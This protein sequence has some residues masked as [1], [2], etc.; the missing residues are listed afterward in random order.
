[1]L[2]T[3]QDPIDID[4]GVTDDQARKMAANLNFKGKQRDEAARQIQRLYGLF[5]K[6]DATQVEINP[7]GETPDGQGNCHSSPFSVSLLIILGFLTGYL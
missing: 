3:L 4:K 7:F 1:M 6:V 5:L 2:L